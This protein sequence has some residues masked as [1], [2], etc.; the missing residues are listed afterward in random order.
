MTQYINLQ[1]NEP[2]KK[3]YDQSIYHINDILFITVYKIMIQKCY[4]FTVC[5]FMLSHT[6]HYYPIIF[7][8][9]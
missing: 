3:S 1:K 2:E 8:K 6:Y 7:Y 5:K 9:W 4:L